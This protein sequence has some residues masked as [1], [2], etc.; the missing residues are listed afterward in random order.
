MSGHT[1]FSVPAAPGHVHLRVL[2]TTDLHAHVFA[3]DYY[4]DRPCDRVGLA[5]TAGLIATARTEAANVLLFD[6]GDFLQGTPLG[7]YMA[8]EHGPLAGAAHPMI[9]AMNA[10]GYDGATLGNHDFNYGLD[11]LSQ[12][13]ARAAFPVV[14]ANVAVRL[15]ADADTDETLLP[16]YVLLDRM[17]RDASGG[18]WPIRIGV[19]GLLPPQI[20]AWDRKHLEGRVSARDMVSAA[21]TLVPRMRAEGADLVIALAHTGI[22]GGGTDP[23][24]HAAVPLAGVPGIDVILAGHSHLAFPGSG[25]SILPG[26]VDPQ[27]GSIAGK[28]AV[29]AGLWGSHLGVIDLALQ[30]TSA[31]WQVAG[32]ASAVRPIC[33]QRPDGTVAALVSSV[34]AV[35]RAAAAEHDAT[36]AYIRRPVGRSEV[37]MHSYFSLLGDDAAI[38]IVAEAQRWHVRQA[39]A[40]TAA[41]G[42]PVLSAVAPFKSGGRGGPDHYT[43]V[44][45]GDLVIRNI[46]D[47][48]L[49]PNL[50]R[51]V[52]VTGQQL[53]DWLERAA[54][55]Y[56]QIT[57]G[58]PDQPLLDPDFPSYNF[59]VISGLRY[60]IDL[61]QPSRFSPCGQLAAPGA[62]RILDLFHDGLPVARDATFIIATNDFRASGAGNFWGADEDSIVLSGKDSTRDILLRYVSAMGAL[63]PQPQGTWCFAPLPGTSVLFETGPRSA[64]Y[65][66]ELKG[67]RLDP[68][69]LNRAG[70]ACYRLHL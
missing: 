28:P 11:F 3:Y 38:Q 8:H 42:L 31:G 52:K 22:G 64:A 68:L 48:Y 69:G 45:A 24:E 67:L 62:Y 2:E 4:A 53:A 43:E 37:A 61:T 19:I 21:R 63:R 49:Y 13:L 1:A 12:A 51:A 54:G 27:R 34:A 40:G 25:L 50:I 6:N 7:D 70:F 23:H 44:A 26:V 65:L 9:A 41:E 56:R 66:H 35:E 60:R 17:L 30:R 10:V 59:D 33:A 14:S 47:L 15:G 32:F 29:M 57:P 46:A 18:A 36:L 5:R 39:L 16:P 20:T 55:I 58:L